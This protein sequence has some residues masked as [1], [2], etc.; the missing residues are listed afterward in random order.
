M[1]WWYFVINV[2]FPS[3]F[4]NDELV[5]VRQAPEHGYRNIYSLFDYHDPI[6]SRMVRHFKNHN[7]RQLAKWCAS[8][9]SETLIPILSERQQFSEFT[10][11]LVI[12]IP[13][14]AKRMHERGFN[15]SRLLARALARKQHW[16][17]NNRALVKRKD[18]PKQ[19]LIQKRS[20]RIKNARG[21][22]GVQKK[23]QSDI[24]NQ[25]IILIDDL[26]TTGATLHEAMRI[27]TKAG[28]RNIL[29]VTLAH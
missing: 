10:N 17:D 3:S 4:T 25:D 6:M 19:A 1:K 12:S 9:I 24:Q 5:H 13:L 20:E 11:P 15:Q 26:V 22:F 14:S 18:T 23:Y 27:L 8:K 29:A 7:D 21:M 16:S 2:F 28:A